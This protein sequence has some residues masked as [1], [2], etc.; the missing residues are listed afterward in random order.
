MRHAFLN[1]FGISASLLALFLGARCFGYALDSE[2]T[3]PGVCSDL[4]TQL[5]CARHG[6]EGCLQSQ[7][8]D[9]QAQVQS[10]SS[11]SAETDFCGFNSSIIDYSSVCVAQ[12][13]CS[14]SEA[15]ECLELEEGA[16]P[17]DCK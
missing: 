13:P 16:D 6:L 12:E 2:C 17:A 4:A 8:D 9:A 7:V 5:Q 10:L 14:I 3:L 1:F 15:L 11:L